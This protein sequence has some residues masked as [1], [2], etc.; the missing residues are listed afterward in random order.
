MLDTGTAFEVT[1]DADV[2]LHNWGYTAE[3]VAQR[4][5]SALFSGSRVKVRVDDISVTAKE[6]VIISVRRL[7]HRGCG[8]VKAKKGRA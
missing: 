3:E 4:M 5:G 2:C 7:G 6:G 8:G 1:H